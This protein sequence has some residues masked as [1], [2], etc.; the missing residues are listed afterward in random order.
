MSYSTHNQSSWPYLV[1]L[2]DQHIKLAPEGEGFFCDVAAPDR[3]VRLVRPM[4]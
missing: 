4:R 1:N 2:L 3:Y